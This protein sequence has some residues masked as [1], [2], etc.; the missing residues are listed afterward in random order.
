MF[1][2]VDSTAKGD[3]AMQCAEEI[4]MARTDDTHCMYVQWSMDVPT[5]FPANDAS[6]STGPLLTPQGR[7]IELFY[8]QDGVPGAKNI[9]LSVSYP[10]GEPGST[11][12]WEVIGYSD[13]PDKYVPP[14][15]M[16][17]TIPTIESFLPINFT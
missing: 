13:T 17:Y 3:L 2:Y 6:L 12:R 5:D 4:R 10:G 11:V 9:V 8:V 16:Q 1:I 7:Q 14:Q 15:Q